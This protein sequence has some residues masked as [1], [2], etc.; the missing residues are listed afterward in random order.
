MAQQ[1]T[2]P[3][4]KM[5]NM[6]YL[7]L[8]AM[9][10]LNVSSEILKAFHKL[11]TSMENSGKNLDDAN[12]KL[13][14]AL[15]QEVTVQGEKAKVYRDRAYEARKITEEFNSYV[16]GV[17]KMFL[18]KNGGR[19]ED[20]QLKDADNMDASM[21]FFMN[22]KNGNEKG[23]EL[24][25]KINSTREKLVALLDDKDKSNFKS[26]LK[27]EDPLPD[28]EGRKI[29]WLEETFEKLPLAATFANLTKYQN[30][31]KKTESDVIATLA[32][33]VNI[34]DVH[35]NTVEA[36]IVAP[37]SS[38][39]TGQTFTAN[40]FLSGYNKNENY[41]MT[42]NG[43]P[44]DVK[45][46]KGV[47]KI[48]PNAEGIYKY[49]AKIMV[50]DPVTGVLKPYI[51]SGEYQVFNPQASVSVANMRVFYA[52]IDNP[53]DITVPGYRPDQITATAD[54]A[55]LNGS[56]GKYI[57]T[58]G[59]SQ[60]RI[61]KINV[62]AKADDGST[63]NFVQLFNTRPMPPLEN[64]INGNTGGV[65]TVEE[66]RTFNFLHCDFGQYFPITTQPYQ[67]TKYTCYV[68]SRENLGPM[69]GNGGQLT[70]QIKSAISKC[71]RGDL[72]LFYD[73]EGRGANGVI[74]RRSNNLIFTVK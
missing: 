22:E 49:E 39:S 63:K 23:K 13:L 7:V 50:P 14:T 25:N 34:F 48:T 72:I 30:D 40:V 20:G 64:S 38:I 70:P 52:G 41:Q 36:N 4:Q 21:D 32:K 6:M 45:D 8:T 2:S 33:N 53:V 68:K 31:A 47:Y 57:V 1:K 74:N 19:V 66:A 28:L 12:A 73:V 3:R 59:L 65:I 29:T 54:N 5:I 15:D 16:D 69:P 61:V 58:S 42:M 24:M 9:L 55:S 43:V 10:A 62:V 60:N 17:K 37:F 26:D 27:T 46:G 11:E 56:N 18:E 71:K 35:V 67:V 51:S 44:I